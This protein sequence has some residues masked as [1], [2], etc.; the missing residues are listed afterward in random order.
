MK[1][2][3]LP[4]ALGLS[5]LCPSYLSAQ[6]LQDETVEKMSIVS[7]RIS[8]PYRQLATSV[9]IVD[10]QQI[11]QSMALNVSE[12]L[13]KT[14][15]ISVSNSGG[16]G[17][18]TTLRIRGEDGFRTKLFIDD[19]PISDPSA[20]QVS[21]IFDDI[22]LS[23]ITH[24]EI[25]RGA[26]G[27]AYGADA[28]GVISIYTNDATQGV[29]AKIASQFSRYSTSMLAGELSAGNEVGS[30]YLGATDLHSD[31]FNAQTRDLSGEK[32]GYENT[33]LHVKG[34][35]NLTEHLHAKLVLRDV[36]SSNQYDGCYNNQT[37]ELIDQCI[38]DSENRTA[39]VSLKYTHDE[40]SHAISISQTEVKRDFFSN[41]EFG[42]GNQGTIEKFDYLG[43]TLWDQASL[44]YGADVSK[45]E[46]TGDQ[47]SRVQRG[48]FVEMIAP[49]EAGVTV[50]LGVRHD[51]NDTF[52]HYTSYRIGANY[53]V[54]LANGDELIA[55]GS[56]GTGFR[57]PSLYE[58][59]YND[60]PFAY[61]DAAGLALQQETS[62]G[63]DLGVTLLTLQGLTAELVLF[64]QQIH[65]EIFFDPIAYQGYL[66]GNG[67][68]RSQGVEVSF[69]QQ[70]RKTFSIWGNYTF[71]KSNDNNDE[72]RL[73][74]PRNKANFGVTASLLQD[75]LQFSSS[76]RIVNDS[77]DIGGQA[78]DNY[79]VIDVALKFELSEQISAKVGVENVFNKHYQEVIGFNTPERN[80]SVSL[81]AKL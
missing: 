74:R 40:Q 36:T 5:L 2:K 69:E 35:L 62:E 58:Q 76:V 60:G 22:L 49:F 34:T 6:S 31:G 10:T 50:N 59:N 14:P 72:Q 13:R 8:V 33:S 7:S 66:Q 81:V 39:L 68:S 47:S 18:N 41:D 20:P 1:L 55:K 79:S 61:G 17:K 25:L 21:P 44:V 67:T 51:Y 71:N 27:L 57:A 54:A 28:G 70:L 30:L 73:R 12:L 78:L 80:V 56:Y 37:F 15:G 52:G 48:V 9:T 42:F 53:I 16:L 3:A 77:E 43:S 38:T 11:E 29:N 65:N 63:T 45:E 24:I 46:I 32:D 64:E 23:Q 4:F 19:V 75:R 26:Q